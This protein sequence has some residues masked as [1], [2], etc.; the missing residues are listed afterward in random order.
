MT[1]QIDPTKPTAIVAYTADVRNNFLIAYNEITALQAIVAPIPSQIAAIL[2][3][4]SGGGSFLQLGAGAL[5]R[6]SQDKM[7]ERLSVLDFGVVLDG[8]TDNTANMTNAIQAAASTNKLLYLPGIDD[9]GNIQGCLTGSLV[10][11]VGF[12]GIIGDGIKKS[13]I[14]MNPTTA[15]AISLHA[16]NLANATFSDFTVDTNNVAFNTADTSVLVFHACAQIT[17]ERV[18][19]TGQGSSIGGAA[20]LT[21]NNTN[22]TIRDVSINAVGTP[23]S[24]GLIGFHCGILCSNSHYANISGVRIDGY[25]AYGINFGLSNNCY[26]TNCYCSNTGEGNGFGKPLTGAFAFSFG[27]CTYCTY[28]SCTSINSAVEA[29]NATDCSYCT[30]SD[31]TASWTELVTFVNSHDFGISLATTLT[32]GT[33]HSNY[34]KVIGNTLYNSAKCGLLNNG[35]SLYN[36]FEDNVLSE[37]GTREASPPLGQY[38]NGG[39][40]A[41]IGTMFKNNTVV[42]LVAT[43]PWMFIESSGN[44]NN[45]VV[46]GNTFR[47][48]FTG[49]FSVQ[50]L[51]TFESWDAQVGIKEKALSRDNSINAN[52]GFLNTV[53]NTVVGYPAMGYNIAAGNATSVWRYA[54]VDTASWIQYTNGGFVFWHTDTTGVVGN[55]INDAASCLEVTSGLGK[56]QVN[57]PVATAP[58]S[59]ELAI[60]AV[61]VVAFPTVGFPSIGYN[62]KSGTTGNEWRY[63]ATDKAAWMQFNSGDF[64]FWNAPSGTAGTTIPKVLIAKIDATG[65][66]VTSGGSLY[67]TGGGALPN[68]SIKVGSNSHLQFIGDDFTTVIASI[69]ENGGVP[70][71]HFIDA[72]AQILI[73]GVSVVRQR[74]T[75]FNAFTGATNQGTV[76]DTSTVTLQQLAERVAALQVVMAFNGSID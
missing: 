50:S 52:Y 45:T 70:S 15:A 51:A 74:T 69:S 42:N 9:F 16:T 54:G 1:S 29:F 63:R 17:V 11:P 33:K 3:L 76:Y 30:I 7:R 44:T 66:N 53:A 27:E 10:F 59:T 71:L 6:S 73:G 26:I 72:S 64:W 2:A 38:N 55:L 23:V 40:D 62:I 57:I 31:N 14:V 58:S 24:G 32:D 28:D 75:G 5:P 37:C 19:I 67:L 39:S 35:N 20:I 43:M 13:K 21:N 56:V 8:V 47:G 68:K 49:A 46:G 41:T 61:S 4:I 36:T 18:D 34:N 48:T 22:L 65:I 25:P 12:P 60:G